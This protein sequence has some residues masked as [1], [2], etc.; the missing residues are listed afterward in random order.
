MQNDE[1]LPVTAEDYD[2]EFVEAWAAQED[3]GFIYSESNIAKVY[4]GWQ[5]ARA[6]RYVETPGRFAE[7][8]TE[9]L[10][11][12]CRM[13]ARDNLDPDYSQFMTAVAARLTALSGDDKHP[14]IGPGL[15]PLSSGE[16]RTAGEDAVE[17]VA[18]WLHDE[19]GFDDSFPGRTWPEH[20]DDTGQREGGW[21]KIVPS[22][23]Q[24]KFRDV[25]RRLLTLPATA[26]LSAPQGEVERLRS[27]AKELLDGL[28][29]TYRARNGREVGIE[30]DDGEKCYIVHSEL[31]AGL[32]AALAQTKGEG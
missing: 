12:Q 4:L 30:A 17:T 27:A 1:L 16:G 32:R 18:Q 7:Y 31:V 29:S 2:P 14:E 21:V 22:D 24:A 28:T 8:S 15:P 26:A 19:G 6:T 13:Q 20:P 5:L 25:A 3:A 10:A 11:A 9:N 23:V